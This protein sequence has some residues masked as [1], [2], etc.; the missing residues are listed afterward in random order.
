M[1][2]FMPRRS[3]EK[4]MCTKLFFCLSMMGVELFITHLLKGMGQSCE[5]VPFRFPNTILEQIAIS[6][7]V[8]Q[9]N[10][11]STSGLLSKEGA[12][13]TQRY[14][15]Y[16]SPLFSSIII[17]HNCEGQVSVLLWTLT[18]SNPVV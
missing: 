12:I 14:T 15:G 18:I 4:F 17:P 13:R 11:F 10:L 6:R 8:S 16:F 7:Q 1:I 9:S 5:A 2:P 3:Q